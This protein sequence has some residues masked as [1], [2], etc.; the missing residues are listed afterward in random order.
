[1]F[2]PSRRS[3]LSILFCGEWIAR[4]LDSSQKNWSNKADYPNDNDRCSFMFSLR[5]TLILIML[6]AKWISFQLPWHAQPFQSTLG[7]HQMRPSMWSNRRWGR[8][9]NLLWWANQGRRSARR[10][11]WPVSLIAEASTGVRMIWSLQPQ[12]SVSMVSIR[13]MTR[14]WPSTKQW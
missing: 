8:Q 3:S 1:M 7:W 2:V 14:Y 11:S 12:S 9:C 5:N 6:C 4:A 10:G 13:W